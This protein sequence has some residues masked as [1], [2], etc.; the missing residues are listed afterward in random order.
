MS[1]KRAACCRELYSRDINKEA[2]SHSRQGDPFLPTQC[3]PS[4][5]L[6]D[7]GCAKEHG[8]PALWARPAASMAMD[9][10]RIDAFGVEFVLA[11]KSPHHLTLGVL[12]QA[13]ATHT[14][15]IARARLRDSV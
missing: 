6:Q 11:W 2:L 10:P 9:K 15:G 4:I 1:L 8:T 5:R 14:G 7:H 13:Y 12:L 3:W